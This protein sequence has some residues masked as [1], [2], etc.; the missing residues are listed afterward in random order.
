MANADE[1]R[2]TSTTQPTIVLSQFQLKQHPHSLTQFSLEAALSSSFCC[3]VSPTPPG[4][5]NSST[6]LFVTANSSSVN[7]GCRNELVGAF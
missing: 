7:R 3:S 2:Q 4:L 6:S 1:E 5:P